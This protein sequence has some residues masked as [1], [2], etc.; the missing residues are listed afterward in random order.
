MPGAVEELLHAVVV[1]GLQG[2]DQRMVGAVA[3]GDEELRQPHAH[4]F[5]H[6][7]DAV[8]AE[9]RRRGRL[10]G[11][12]AALC[13]PLGKPAIEHEEIGRGQALVIQVVEQPG[14]HHVAALVIDDDAPAWADAPG[15]DALFHRGPRRLIH[16]VAVQVRAH[17]AGNVPGR[18]QRCH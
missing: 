17:R 13:A 8:A 2:L 18:M 12:G 14:G 15:L 11:D 4:L 6:C 7:G 16:A 3:G 1:G 9:G 5:A 10:L